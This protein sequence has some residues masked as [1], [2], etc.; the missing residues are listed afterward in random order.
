MSF[1]IPK[2]QSDIQARIE[3]LKLEKKRKEDMLALLV[4]AK[5]KNGVELADAEE[6][7]KKDIASIVVPVSTVVATPDTTLTTTSPDIEPTINTSHEAKIITLKNQIAGLDTE[8][9][10]L[11]SVYA[12]G[13]ELRT[14]EIEQVESEK[15]KKATDLGIVKK[16]IDAL[17]QSIEQDARIPVLRKQLE[18]VIKSIVTESLKRSEGKPTLQ[19]L[20]LQKNKTGTGYV[21][22]ASIKAQVGVSLTF[23]IVSDSSQLLLK[24]HKVDAGFFTGKAEKAITPHMN[25]LMPAVMEKLKET[26]AK[27]IEVEKI[28]IDGES[29]NFVKKDKP[30]TPNTALLDEKKQAFADLEKEAQVLFTQIQT[31]KEQQAQKDKDY[32]VELKDLEAK[33][34]VLEKTLATLEAGNTTTT[35][36]KINAVHVLATPISVSYNMTKSQKMLAEIR[37]KVGKNVIPEIHTTTIQPVAPIVPQTISVVPDPI[38]VPDTI[39]P[40]QITNNEKPPRTALEILEEIRKKTEKQ[41]Q[42]SVIQ[43]PKTIIAP[44]VVPKKI[45]PVLAPEAKKKTEREKREEA[46]MSR[47]KFIRN[48][49]LG[50]VALATTGIGALLLG[51]KTEEVEDELKEAGNNNEQSIADLEQAKKDLATK[52]TEERE[53]AEQELVKNIAEKMDKD[54]FNKLSFSAKIFYLEEIKR[55]VENNE[56]LENHLFVDKDTA[57]VYLLGKNGEVLVEDSA[58]LGKALGEDFNTMSIDGNEDFATT[59]SGIYFIGQKNITKADKKRYGENAWRIYYEGDTAINLFIHPISHNNYKARLEAIKTDTPLDNRLSDGCV[60][61]E[62]MDE[63]VP[64]IKE[65]TMIIIFPDTIAGQEPLYLSQDGELLEQKALSPELATL[66]T[67]VEEYANIEKRTS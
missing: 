47:R 28:V 24:N 34:K 56:E 6:E 13:K 45:E 51:K 36:T 37:A 26:Y 66:L 40:V 1:E 31:L 25:Q 12:E 54:L 2:T 38:I 42:T 9:T 16:E 4:V 3:F 15:K 7:V 18:I 29:V 41:P 5:D 33:K 60:N 17:T 53:R 27:D 8:L 62:K 43:P 23:E 50:G 19:T 55:A 59:P 52:E 11:Q 67:K 21:G 64:H 58:V 39:E 49:L 14:K 35:T 30:A 48:S 57:K 32:S 46:E 10:A 65:G 61:V 63:I 44:P 22:S 20:T